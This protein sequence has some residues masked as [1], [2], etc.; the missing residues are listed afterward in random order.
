MSYLVKIVIETVPNSEQRYPTVGD[1]LYNASTDE[2]RMKISDMGNWRHEALV[3]VHELVEFLL[4]RDKGITTAQVDEFDL[5]YEEARSDGD[6]SEPGDSG[7]AP[8]RDQ[9]CF[10]T[11][12]ERMLCAAM[13]IS[14][15]EYDT[16]VGT[17]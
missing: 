13:G 3:A 14:W 7:A 10:A 1:W 4:C 5:A 16:T 12:V 9:H 6:T 17:L 15:N 8:Y 2:L 11:S